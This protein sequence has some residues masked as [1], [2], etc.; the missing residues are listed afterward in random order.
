MSH[1]QFDPEYS[2]ATILATIQASEAE[3]GKSQVT[4]TGPLETDEDRIRD[5]ATISIFVQILQTQTQTEANGTNVIHGVGLKR[6]ECPVTIQSGG[7]R[8]GPALGIATT[9]EQYSKPKEH[10]S[11]TWSQKFKFT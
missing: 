4:I 11:W 10:Y 6:W 3:P 2:L 9:V 7:F 5:E 8:P 1:S